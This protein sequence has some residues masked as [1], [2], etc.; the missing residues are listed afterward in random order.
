M[1]RVLTSTLG[2]KS[3]VLALPANI[4]VAVEAGISKEKY[5]YCKLATSVTPVRKPELGRLAQAY[6]MTL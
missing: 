3:P 5:Q 6:R 2:L 1:R 4:I